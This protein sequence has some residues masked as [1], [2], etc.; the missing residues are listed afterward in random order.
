MYTECRKS[1][2]TLQPTW[3]QNFTDTNFTFIDYTKCSNCL[4][5]ALSYCL[6]LSGKLAH[7]V[8]QSCR[9]SYLRAFYCVLSGS[10]RGEDVN[11]AVLGRLPLIAA[12]TA[13]NSAVLGLSVVKHRVPG[14]FCATLYIT[15]RSLCF[16]HSSYKLMDRVTVETAVRAESGCDRNWTLCFWPIKDT[17]ICFWLITDMEICFWLITGMKICFWLITDMEICFWLIK[18]MEICFWLIT[19]MEIC[20]WLITDMENCFWLIIDMEICF[21]LI[22]DMEKCCWLITDMKICFWSIT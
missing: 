6:S 21:C 18:D 2:L 3:Q 8:S 11:C 4:P 14:D 19:D 1:H 12:L 5:F 9:L 17:E 16:V 7:T 13:Q 10:C 20:F 15:F 22:T